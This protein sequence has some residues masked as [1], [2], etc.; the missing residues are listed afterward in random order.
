MV[1]NGKW[2]QHTDDAVRQNRADIDQLKSE[3]RDRSEH[4]WRL[5]LIILS[6]IVLPVVAAGV[7]ALFQYVI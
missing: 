7:A 2:Q 5:A 1:A 3:F 4:T 6:G